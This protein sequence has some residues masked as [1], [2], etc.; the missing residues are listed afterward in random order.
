[1]HKWQ[2]QEA[3]SKLS[4]VVNEAI[5]HGPQAITR[6]GQ[7]TVIVISFE[8]YS[9]LI[10]PRENIVDFFD[11]SPLKGLELDLSRSQELPRDIN[12]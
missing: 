1:M 10:K 3:K 5:A 6:R 4:K 7:N 9:K 8:D 12:L 2:I 11:K